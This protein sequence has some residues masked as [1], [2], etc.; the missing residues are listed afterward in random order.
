MALPDTV[1]RLLEQLDTN[2]RTMPPTLLYN[3]GWM[4]RLVLNAGVSGL[5]PGDFPQK[6]RWYSEAQLRTPFGRDKGAKYEGNTHA[7]GVIGDFLDTS[8]TESGLN[9]ASDSKCFLVIEAKMYSPL[10]S[11][12]KHAP[13][14][15]QA[16]RN[17]ACMA[18]TLQRAGCQPKFMST[19]GF[20]VIAP[21]SQIDSGIF[22]APMSPQSIRD[23]VSNRIQ[24]FTGA[25]HDELIRWQTDWFLPLVAK[26]ESQSLKCLSWEHLIEQISSTDAST[27]KEIGDFY[28]KCKQYNRAVSRSFD[29]T[30]LPSR[31][32]QYSLTN[33]KYQGQHVRVCSAGLKNSRVYREGYR[34]ES[35]LV[36]NLHLRLVPESRPKED[37]RPGHVYKWMKAP[38][39]A[40]LVKVINVGDCNS[41]VV[42]ENTGGSSFKVPNHHLEEPLSLSES[43]ESAP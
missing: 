13:G 31:G 26:M 17:V 3:E 24:Q 15:D 43:S 12:T 21:Q 25:S 39:E 33:G 41:R 18:R 9:L 42:Q 32:M 16:A 5:I 30:G 27:G 20:C 8:D 37:P 34:E 22:D 4:L 7:D 19:V 29:S 36:P 35:F 23:R 28:E 6:S 14:Y 10:S 1:I 38:D 40:V 11:G 2:S